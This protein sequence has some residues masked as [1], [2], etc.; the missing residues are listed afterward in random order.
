MTSRANASPALEPSPEAVKAAR[1][2]L[3]DHGVAATDEVVRDAL[4][5][6]LAIEAARLDR[7]A[8]EAAA[9]CLLRIQEVT[10]EALAVLVQPN[11]PTVQMSAPSAAPRGRA[12]PHPPPSPPP[13]LGRDQPV[14]LAEVVRSR[15]G[16]DL[17]PEP[18]SRPLAPPTPPPFPARQPE[19]RRPVFK[20]PRGR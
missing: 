18:P 16:E 15:L 6:V 11:S 5:S 4:R 19:P 10:R 2:R 9:A 14:N 8:R 17:P 1:E 13:P 3:R 12:T 20:R 7:R